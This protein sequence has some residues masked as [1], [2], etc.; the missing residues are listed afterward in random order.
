MASASGAQAGVTT[1]LLGDL[2]KY[3]LEITFVL[4]IGVLAVVATTGASAVQGLVLLGRFV[5]AGSRILPS[6]VR[7]INALAGVRLARSPLEH[8]VRVHALMQQ[9]QSAEVS[10]VVTEAV[11]QGDLAIRD[12]RFSY[13]DHTEREVLRGVDLDIPMG[14]SVAVV[15]AS[16]AAKSTLVD[17]LLGLQQPTAGSVRAGGVSIFDNLPALQRQVAVVPQDVTL[18]DSSIGENIAF[19]EALDLE[20]LAQAMER[21][22]LTDLVATLPEGVNTSAG[23]RGARLSG[24]QRQRIGIARALY[25]NPSLL[26]LDEATSALD[27][28]TERRLTDTIEALRGKVTVVVVAHRLSTVRHCDQFAFMDRGR[29]ATLGTFD[30][31]ASQNPDFA[32]LVKLGS[33]DPNPTTF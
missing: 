20:R 7:L 32:R 2:P 27:N 6:S 19:D 10:S 4:G 25:R 12:L 15:G 21:A 1:N 31:V 17:I 16:G 8:L 13:S 14:S 26:V 3:F 23:E 24:G 22:Q 18:L 33:L 11:P 30:E 5:A 28:E 29:V 9:N